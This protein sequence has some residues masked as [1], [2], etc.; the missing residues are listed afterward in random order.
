MCSRVG[1]ENDGTKGSYRA[2]VSNIS[3]KGSISK[4]LGQKKQQCQEESISMNKAKRAR[5]RMSS[6]NNR[7]RAQ[8][9]SEYHDPKIAKKNKANRQRKPTTLPHQ[10]HPL[11]CSFIPLKSLLIVF[12]SSVCSPGISPTDIRSLSES[13]KRS[14][15]LYDSNIALSFV[16]ESL[17]GCTFGGARL[18]WLR[19]GGEGGGGGDVEDAARLWG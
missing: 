9:E 12:T 7:R 19:G 18:A 14:K 10:V 16:E 6:G 1:D 8:C 5:K 2:S 3:T 15:F 17:L 11:I 13:T 4:R